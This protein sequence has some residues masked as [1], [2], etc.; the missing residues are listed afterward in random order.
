MYLGKEPGTKANR[1]YDP[2]AGVLHVSRD[3]MFQV[4]KT[5]PWEQQSASEVLFLNS[6]TVVGHLFI[7]V[8]N[9]DLEQEAVTPMQPRVSNMSGSSVETEGGFDSSG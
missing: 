7:G 5:W 2:V 6:F 1:L 4:E 9:A 3:V 8:D